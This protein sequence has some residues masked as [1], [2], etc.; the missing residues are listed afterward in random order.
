MAIRV[1]AISSTPRPGGNSER[2]LEKA[3]EGAISAG[4][5]AKTV[6]LRKLKIGPCAECCACFK[7]GKCRIADDYQGVFEVMLKADRIIFASPVFFMTVSAQAKLLIDRCQC[8]WSR[9]YVL[10]QPVC[11]DGPEDR[12]GMVIAVGGSASKKMFESV[13]MTMKYFFDALDVHYT[14]NLFVNRVDA[15]GEIDDHPTALKEAWRLGREL[16]P[17]EKPAAKKPVDVALYDA[18]AAKK[19]RF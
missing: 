6:Y 18:P 16:V 13:R 10:K 4:A 7:L 1:L 19:P 11:P 17:G 3:V 2:L 12:R 14:L 15:K 9:K 8:L 5:D